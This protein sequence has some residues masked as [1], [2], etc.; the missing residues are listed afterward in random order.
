MRR[1]TVVEKEIEGLRKVA[2]DLRSQKEV[3]I[4]R[5]KDAV[6][7]EL[8]VAH[9]RELETK[10]ELNSMLRDKESGQPGNAA[11]GEGSPNS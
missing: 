10:D 4:S 8:R 2:D 11:V 6:R 7:E 9:Q 3:E 1:Y 5:A